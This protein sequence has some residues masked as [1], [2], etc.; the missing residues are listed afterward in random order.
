MLLLWADYR[1]VSQPF[2]NLYGA[3]PSP[4]AFGRLSRHQLL[5][6]P[7]HLAVDGETLNMT[8]HR[9]DIFGKRLVVAD[10]KLSSEG[11]RLS[12]WKLRCK[13]EACIYR[14]AREIIH[15]NIAFELWQKMFGDFWQKLLPITSVIYILDIS[16]FVILLYSILASWQDFGSY[17]RGTT[18]FLELR[19]LSIYVKDFV[20]FV[21]FPLPMTVFGIFLAGMM[22]QWSYLCDKPDCVMAYMF[23]DNFDCKEP[24]LR[25]EQERK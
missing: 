17:A 10:V 20:L 4:Q 15:D 18:L 24:N 14:Y 3:N 11:F 13:A 22:I 16:V 9:E 6:M 19:G 8:L 2:P 23:H 12:L 21:I 1:L 25:A 5:E 7:R